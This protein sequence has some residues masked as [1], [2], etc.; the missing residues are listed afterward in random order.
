MSEEEEFLKYKERKSYISATP[1]GKRINNPLRISLY[2]FLACAFISSYFDAGII[3]G[4]VDEIKK[5]LETDDVGF[6][7]IGSIDYLGRILASM[8]YLIL[9]HENH[10]KF[11]MV[12]ACLLQGIVLIFTPFL[13]YLIENKTALYFTVFTQRILCGISQAY[14]C[15]YIPVWIDQFGRPNKRI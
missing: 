5:D 12:F 10:R 13:V 11:L 4:A 2:I 14:F 9:I 8:V 1:T 15:I 3:P 6:G 7:L